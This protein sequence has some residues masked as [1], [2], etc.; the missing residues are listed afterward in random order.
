MAIDF[1][2]MNVVSNSVLKSLSFKFLCLKILSDYGNY[3]E[4]YVFD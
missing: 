4:L 3:S 1:R 2:H